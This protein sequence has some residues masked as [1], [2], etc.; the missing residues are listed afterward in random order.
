MYGNPDSGIQETF[1][2]G[3]RNFTFWNPKSISRN[4]EFRKLTFWNPESYYL[5]SR[6]LLF[7]I[8][9]PTFRN[10]ESGIRNPGLGI[11][12]PGK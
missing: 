11:R 10:L 2:R 12:N 6:I 5:E 7:G 8:P 4:P 9:N 3:I 1:A